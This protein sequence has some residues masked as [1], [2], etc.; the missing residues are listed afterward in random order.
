VRVN[1]PARPD[2]LESAVGCFLASCWNAVFD[3]IAS[4][5]QIYKRAAKLPGRPGQSL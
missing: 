1:N 5:M 2:G 4:E 3:R